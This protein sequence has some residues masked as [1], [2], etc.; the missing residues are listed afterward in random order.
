MPFND[1]IFGNPTIHKDSFVSSRSAVIGRVIIKE[2]VIVAPN[3]SIRADEEG[4]FMICKGT[5]IQDGVTIHGL[6]G[7]HVD[8]DGEK[9]SVYIGSHC[10]IAHNAIVHGPSKIGKKTFVGFN[11][12]VIG[13]TIGEKCYLDHGAI[14]EGVT[15]PDGVFIPF[16]KINSQEQADKLQPIPSEKKK[17]FNKHV[18]DTNKKL[19]VLYRERRKLKQRNIFQK[20]FYAVKDFIT[21]FHKK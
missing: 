18:V 9:Y 6:G 7:Q 13:S 21:A 8:V 14:V 11:A 1:K 4:P 2:F 10:S 15:I 19:R 12:Q 16:G 20:L 17:E 5:N 3:A